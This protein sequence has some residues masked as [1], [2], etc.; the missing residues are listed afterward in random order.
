MARPTRNDTR[1][2]QNRR[3]EIA[4]RAARL[5]ATEGL[6]DYAAAKQKAARQ[7]GVTTSMSLPNNQEIESALEAYQS[8]FQRQTQPME[9]QAARVAA[10]EVM[11]WLD[12]FAP[13]LVGAVFSGTANH[14]SAIELE[15]IG[16]DAKALDLFLLNEQVSYSTTPL[17][18]TSLRRDAKPSTPLLIYKFIV[19]SYPVSLAL[20]PN[21]A[22]R[23]AYHGDHGFKQ[24]RAQRK[25]VAALLGI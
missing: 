21:H 7:L 19:D 6:T 14:F 22:S 24:A 2:Q 5:I 4:D 10:L 3:A 17:K 12:Q 11:R 9:C 8:L 15:I 20:F 13:W 18:S 1:H 25:E 23:E 16:H